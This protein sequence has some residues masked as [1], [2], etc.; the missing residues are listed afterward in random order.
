MLYKWK[1]EHQG[2]TR[3]V[4]QRARLKQC[5]FTVL[6]LIE[7]SLQDL[8]RAESVP[9]IKLENTINELQLHYGFHLKLVS[10]IDQTVECILSKKKKLTS[11][12]IANLV[13]F[14]TYMLWE[15]RLTVSALTLEE[16]GRLT[17]KSKNVTIHQA[18]MV[19]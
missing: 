17:S 2:P 14:F 18:F 19:R 12:V 13:S 15:G 4:E 11:T 3:F 16:F 6:Y 1:D 5:G 9:L 10:N 8:A 7:G